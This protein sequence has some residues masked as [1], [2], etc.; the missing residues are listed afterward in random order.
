MTIRTKLLVVLTALA[1]LL[2]VQ[3]GLSL[4]CAISIRRDSD[5]FESV[6]VSESRLAHSMMETLSKLQTRLSNPQPASDWFARD[7]SALI[8]DLRRNLDS[9]GKSAGREL[10]GIKPASAGLRASLQNQLPV[11]NDIKTQLNGL[12]MQLR[13]ARNSVATSPG[14][15]ELSR[16]NLAGLRAAL[17]RFNDVLMAESL[18][19]S[20]V[21][22]GNAQRS[23]HWMLIIVALVTL[24]VLAL[25]FLLAMIFKPLAELAGAAEDVAG[26]DRLRRLKVVRRDEFGV[27]ATAFN[28]MLDVL[29]KT[30][31]TMDVLENKVHERTAAL[32]EEIKVRHVVEKELRRSEHNL[33][34]TLNSIGDGVLVVNADGLVVRMNP[35]AGQLT[36]W[37]ME[38]VYGQPVENVFCIVDET[39]RSKVPV[40]ITDA[41]ATG[42]VIGIAN[43][44]ILIGRLDVE[45]PI[46]TS[47]APILDSDGKVA[48][49]ILVFR[50]VS[51]ERSAQEEILRLNRELEQR[52]ENRTSELL[53]SERRHRTLLAN[54]QG[55]AYR[56][57]VDQD[58][59]MEFVSEGCRDLL[60]IE[61]EQLTAG[62]ILYRTLIHPEDRDRVLSEV[63][64]SIVHQTGFAIEYRVNHSSEEWRSVWE[65]G[66]AVLDSDGKVVALEGY[67]TDMTRRVDAEREHRTLEEQVR[68]AQKMEAIGTLAGGIAHD[69]NNV[70]AAILGS[71]ELVRMDLAA[72][73]PGREFLDQIFVAGN[74]AR[75]VV[76]QILTF[77]QRRESERSIIQLDPIVKEC[78]KLLRSTIPAMVDISCHVD[79]DCSPVLADPTQVH[80]IIMNLCTNSWHALPERGG[81]IKVILTMHELDGAALNAHNDLRA[82]PYVR[83]SIGDNGIGMDQA[84]L[85]RIFEPFFTTKPAGK[86]SGLGL[87]VVHGIVKS[88]EGAITVES[89]PG[90][91]TFFHIYFPPQA[92]EENEVQTE[93]KIAFT[94]NHERIMFVDDDVSAGQVMEKVLNRFGYKVTWFQRPEEAL[95]EFNDHPKGYDLV[96]SDLAMPGMTGDNLAAAMLC[97]RPDIPILITTGLIDSAI[98]KKAQ[99][100]GVCNVLLKPVSASVLAREIAQRLADRGG[101]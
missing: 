23:Q 54:L 69:F 52:V 38:S 40:P 36:G 70:L 22:F 24:T 12:E 3:G 28:H 86:G 77:S 45:H 100:I 13:D 65:Q 4:Q 17:T 59:P 67:V 97:T 95:A 56:C 76:Q 72:D 5:R 33:A 27:M 98:L 43:H 10:D 75:E 61:P 44:T 42:K 39:S 66:R 84:T 80:Q 101:I 96:V 89:E 18:S 68:R 88:H 74:R 64:S 81:W 16:R 93:L 55:M 78:V 35:V 51:E 87:S 19:E 94:G 1:A 47:C 53:E 99:E 50:D 91:G 32:E 21:I 71:A 57:R 25:G 83:L 2:L 63:E 92:S 73:H 9:A 85:S 30:S 90:K 15:A 7:T 82:G 34:T 79:P 46:A 14:V 26:G 20:Q 37:A 49:A 60:G 6:V 31:I 29:Q 41:M 8:Q 48:G 11:L 62:R 58:W